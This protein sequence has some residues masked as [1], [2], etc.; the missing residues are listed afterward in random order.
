MG[1]TEDELLHML[2]E[3]VGSLKAQVSEQERQARKFYDAYGKERA[4]VGRV[5]R[6]HFAYRG[7]SEFDSCAECNRV[8]GGQEVP[9]PCAT[10]EALDGASP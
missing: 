9:W 1:F 10:I 4:A 5:R 2:G 8:S 6:L 7:P 3:R